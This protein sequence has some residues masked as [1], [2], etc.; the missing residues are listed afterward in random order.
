MDK[1]GAIVI[2]GDRRNDHDFSEGKACITESGKIGGK[3]GFINKAGQSFVQPQFLDCRDFHGGLAAV[4]L[5]R[6]PLSYSFLRHVFGED[7]YSEKHAEVWGFI[8][9]TGKIAIQPK[10]FWVGD[11]SEGLAPVWADGKIGYIDGSGNFAIKPT[12]DV[13]DYTAMNTPDDWSNAY[14]TL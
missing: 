10:Y 8:D 3:K 11:L 13:G 12:F 14:Y 2:P 6:Y 5:K 9:E 7:P 1:T 4:Q